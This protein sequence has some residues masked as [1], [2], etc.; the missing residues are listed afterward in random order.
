MGG[1]GCPVCSKS[2]GFAE[3]VSAMN[4]TWHK[5]CFACNECKK[6]LDTGSF[7]DGKDSKVYCKNCYAKL[8]GPKG[9]GYGGALPTTGKLAGES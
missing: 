2:V 9:Y 6:R 1:N 5:D 8:F 4:A 7:C 3:K